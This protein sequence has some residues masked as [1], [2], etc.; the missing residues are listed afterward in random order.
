MSDQP[1]SQNHPFPTFNGPIFFST[2]HTAHA[3]DHT[4]IQRVTRSLARELQASGLKVEFVEWVHRKRR[5]VILDDSAREKL[6]RDG[7]PPFES[8][9]A[10]WSRVMPEIA[11]G[12][13]QFNSELAKISTRSALYG[14]DLIRRYEQRMQ[15]VVHPIPNVPAWIGFLP[16]PR[17]ARRSI[18]RA[19]RRWKNFLVQRKDRCRIRSYIRDVVSARRLQDRMIRQMV[20]LLEKQRDYSAKLVSKEQDAWLYKQTRDALAHA[21][22]PRRFKRQST[23]LSKPIKGVDDTNLSR[24][25]DL[26][27]FAL[28]LRMSSTR[29]EPPA[30]SWLIVPELMKPAD[31]RGILRY[32]RRRR[33]NLAMLFHDAIAV[34]HP[35]L[36]SETI[37]AD[38]KDY[39]RSVCRCDLILS[40]SQQ[41]ADDLTAFAQ[42]EGM[43]LPP[44]RVCPNGS[45]FPGERP[46]AGQ[47][48]SPPIRVLCVGTIDPRKNHTSLVQA[49][50]RIRETKPTLNLELTLVGNAYPGSGDLAAEINRACERDPGL[51]WI[52][53][54]NDPEL[55]RT[56]RECHFTVFPSLVEGFGIPVLESIWFGRPCICSAD[57]AVG[58]RAIGGGCLTI[59][60]TNPEALA[61]A[62]VALATD[63]T[64][65]QRLTR[66][67]QSRPLRTW[68]DQAV[69]MTAI[70]AEAP[71]RFQPK[72]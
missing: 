8:T 21:E 69:E 30:C 5:F 23:D 15:A 43:A 2:G 70:V 58:E 7:G 53:G 4:G 71:T 61:K 64:L 6:S 9:D 37:R 47:P 59:D 54:A 68:R 39:M 31:M 13:P 35:E 65:R 18:R 46:T 14:D 57:G 16:L 12:I 19:I 48:P 36:V 67:A 25:R 26:D 3:T 38:H 11:V 51:K 17:I 20:Q 60:V 29:F 63:E 22:D 40:V 10:L 62:M 56:Y 49:L 32:C 33:V 66:E 1:R 41:S 72:N 44:V 52:R 27:L 45:S 42:A 34:T 55:E 50:R 28:T 24:H